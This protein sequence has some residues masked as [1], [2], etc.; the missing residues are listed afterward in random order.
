VLRQP[1]PDFGWARYLEA[2]HSDCR[3]EGI[4]FEVLDKSEAGTNV[5]KTF[6]KTD[7]I[8]KL[9]ELRL[10]FSRRPER[11]IRIRLE[12]DTNPPAGSVCETHYINFPRVAA[13]TVQTLASSFAGKCHALLCRQYAKGRDWYDFAW[14]VARKTA[15]NFALLEQAIAQVGPWAGQNVKT[16]PTWLIARL[17][18]KIGSIDWPVAREDVRRFIPA[19]QQDSLE[20]WKADY[21]LYLTER[22]REHF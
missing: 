14:Y 6:L 17:K 9:L 2:V 19:R 3:I 13:I 7:S 4:E 16:D 8:G 11:K 21:F 12:I 1:D 10:P 20:L 15:V 22:L 18:E 5:R